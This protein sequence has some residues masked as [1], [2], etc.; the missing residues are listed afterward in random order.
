M[1]TINQSTFTFLSDL[2]ANNNRDW[3]IANKASYELAKSNIESFAQQVISHFLKID[4]SIQPVEGKKAVFRIYR[5]VRF[6][7]DKTPYKN[8]FG[9]GFSEKGRSVNWP[10]YYIQIQPNNSFIAG[11]YW[12]PESVHLKAIRQEIDY[13]GSYL[14]KLLSSEKFTNYFDRFDQSD[15]LINPPKGYDVENEFI[16][17]LK[18]KSFTVMHKFEDR[19]MMDKQILDKIIEGL[20]L[21]YPLNSFLSQ[22]ISST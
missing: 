16:E 1:T 2:E 13:N 9:I 8:N 12:M 3:F 18:L 10:G 17:H 11:G 21:I 20:S 19:E 22:A 4:S 14:N 7:K 15:K 6:S 5:D